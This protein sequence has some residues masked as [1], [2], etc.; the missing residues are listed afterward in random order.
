MP[1]S[2]ERRAAPDRH[3]RWRN[4]EPPSHGASLLVRGYDLR[5]Q[6]RIFRNQSFVLEQ[7]F[8]IAR[9]FQRSPEPFRRWVERVVREDHAAAKSQLWPCVP[10]ASKSPERRRVLEAESQRNR[11]SNCL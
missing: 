8:P 10:S 11:R 2:K 4:K 6:S 7:A 1:S 5:R 9:C 3:P